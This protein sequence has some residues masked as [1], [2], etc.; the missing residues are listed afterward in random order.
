MA[1]ASFRPR[2]RVDRVAAELR[3]RLVEPPPPGPER[4]ASRPGPRRESWWRRRL[5]RR[6]GLLTTL[7]VFAA[8]AGSLGAVA[9]SLRTDVQAGL[10]E[11]LR[12]A[13]LTLDTLVFQQGSVIGAG[14]GA[15]AGA[16]FI[17]ALLTSGVVDAQTL[18]G[19]A[20]EQRAALAVDLLVLL[21]AQSRVR[22]A[23]PSG[24]ALGDLTRVM[25]SDAQVVRLGG[26]VF[27]VISRPVT[28]DGREVGYVVAGNQLGAA[29]LDYLGRQSGAES[30]LV[31]GGAVRAA[32]LR[33]VKASDLAAAA[34][35]PSGIAALTISG[36]RVVAARAPLGDQAEVVLLRSHEQAFRRF[37]GTLLRLAWVGGVAF[38]AA[39][40]LSLL[41]GRGIAR[42][43]VAVAGV[44][45]HVAEGDLTR[46]VA[47]DSGDEVGALAASVNGMA[48]RVK[49]V[50]LEVRGSSED[51][52][53]TA[54][55]NRRGSERVK[56]GI[57]D[58]LR[59][60]EK[61]A[62]S[63][64]EIAAQ[65]QSV[66]RS[67]QSLTG[68]VETTAAGIEQLEGASRR[69][70]VRFEDLTGA[71][72]RTS[73]TSA[74][75]TRAI[76]V[77]AERS[78]DLHQGV[79]RS[80]A[81]V[82]EMAASLE[83]TARHAD[84]LIAS[85]TK[86]A[87]V[88]AG[89]VATAQEV[90]EQVRQVEQL[91]G[92]AAVEVTA[93]D[94]A[95]RSAL[96][97]MGRI[98]G[99]IRETATQMRGLDSH[100]RDIR[101]MLEVIEDI[102]DQTNLLALNA[103]IEAARAGE[104]GRGFAVVADE[105][106]KLAE[107]SVAATKEI[108]GVVHLVQE[109]TALVARSAAAGEAESHEGM[110]LADR[111]GEALKAIRGEVTR[112]S[113]LA[114]ELGRL[115]SEQSAAFGVVSGAVE[116]MRGTTQEVASTVKEQGRGGERIRAAMVQMRRLTGEVVETTR[117]L[118]MGARAV[119]EAVGEMNRITGDVAGDVRQQVGGI[120][121]I[122]RAAESMRRETH[123]VTSATGEQRKGGELVLEAAESIT[124]VARENLASIEAIAGSA[125]RLAGNSEAL[126]LRIRAFR[127]A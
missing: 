67:A 89:L 123:E 77:V 16:A 13:Q 105:V 60:A 52:A 87:E 3:P 27:L 2:D 122:H 4:P 79:D 72:T 44:V 31:A 21:D 8:I 109:K 38:L 14:T 51:L 45:S 93:G 40:A 20:D 28:V 42:R 83:A 54:E 23:S 50:I 114:T 7:V 96:A 111:A 61:T 37:R 12:R 59:E 124:K 78:S 29:F 120:Q 19:V 58:Q 32:S 94:E 101:R 98:V 127:V 17:Q 46:E 53:S 90:G 103:A 18:Q 104:A 25:G 100:S 71:I 35:P 62:S 64:A 57:E 80:A 81:T 73:G 22:A 82:E 15:L 49:D 9:I 115:T 84:A 43:L 92:R 102:A 95:A 117:E 112:T 91:S 99:G 119:G 121:Q 26:Q 5:A 36:V 108:A 10:E 34:L 63:M 69:L 6:I 125:S 86:T 126:S 75:M 33:S 118:A 56:A 30:A 39:S 41:V 66:S 70:S 11:D 55:A 68:S 107:R 116:Q 47:V 88:V 1:A 24:L 76:E 106:R 97:A 113:D 48:A 110:R 74:E 85:G 65:I